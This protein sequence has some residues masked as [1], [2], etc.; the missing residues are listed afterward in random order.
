MNDATQQIALHDM[1]KLSMLLPI[2]VSGPTAVLDYVGGLVPQD[3]DELSVVFE[4]LHLG[5]GRCAAMQRG[6]QDP[7]LGLDIT[8]NADYSDNY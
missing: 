3:V 8:V 1:V 7:D 5:R 2:P 6:A 4:E